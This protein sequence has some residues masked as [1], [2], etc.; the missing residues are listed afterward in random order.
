MPRH[1]PDPTP[2]Y[3][4]SKS[5]TALGWIGFLA[6]VG[7]GIFMMEYTGGWEHIEAWLGWVVFLYFI[8]IPISKTV[9]EHGGN[10]DFWED[11]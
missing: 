5:V 9:V 3:E 6:I 10:M 4:Y 8:Y 2:K 1:N 7:L 11:E